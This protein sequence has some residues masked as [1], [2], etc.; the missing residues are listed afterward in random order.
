MATT[1]DPDTAI[2]KRRRQTRN[3]EP[4]GGATTLAV[5]AIVVTLIGFWQSFLR[6]PR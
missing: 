2:A 3:T 1:A 5:L 6:H 4:F